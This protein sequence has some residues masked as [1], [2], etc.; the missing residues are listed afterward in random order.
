M[1]EI[2]GLK[3]QS[4]QGGTFVIARL[5]NGEQAMDT[6][7][8]RINNSWWFYACHS[9]QTL[10][11]SYNIY[12]AEPLAF[13]D[14]CSSQVRSSC[15][16]GVWGS[17]VV[18]SIRSSFQRLWRVKGLGPEI[19]IGPLSFQHSCL[20]FLTPRWPQMTAPRQMYGKGLIWGNFWAWII[21]QIN[22]LGTHFLW[23]VIWGHLGILE[24]KV[25]MLE[26]LWYLWGYEVL[27]RVH[28][29][30]CLNLQGGSWVMFLI[31]SFPYLSKKSG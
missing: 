13:E 11:A 1:E 24:S 4:V 17:K 14:T 22:T 29:F 2:V 23:A 27:G 19:I 20:G 21:P 5:H 10:F 31:R 3:G 8:W 16:C 12:L 6:P 30:G 7:R 9:P 26:V 18:E 28:N 15:G 25:T